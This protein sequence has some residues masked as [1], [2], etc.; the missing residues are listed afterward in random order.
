VHNSTKQF[1]AEISPV[2]FDVMTFKE[3]LPVRSKIVIRNPVVEQVNTFTYLG[4]KISYEE[5]ELQKQVKFKDTGILNNVLQPNLVRIQ[6][7]ESTLLFSYRI[8][9]MTK[10]ET[11]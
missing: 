1:G 3:Q 7:N 4:C 10:M 2:T 11:N 9:Y 5:K 8:T 6:C